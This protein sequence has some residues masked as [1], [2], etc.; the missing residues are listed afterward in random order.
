MKKIKFLIAICISSVFISCS[1]DDSDFP[2]D[3]VDTSDDVISSYTNVSLSYITSNDDRVFASVNGRTYDEDAII[4]EIGPIIDLVSV[5][6][7][8]MVKFISP[9]NE[10]SITIP[11]ATDTKIQHLDVS[12]SAS[13][14]DNIEDD[15][16]LKDITVV[17][18]DE[19]IAANDA[20]NS[21]ILF[22][23]ANGRKG[24]IKIKSFNLS[25]ILVDVKVLK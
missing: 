16:L 1:D 19:S 6:D 23:N 15:E 8:N 25:A 20:I 9:N 7:Q 13:D 12:V 11:G 22:E 14:F 24:A 5:S 21:I 2:G 4:D 17:N 18:D 10:M 3:F